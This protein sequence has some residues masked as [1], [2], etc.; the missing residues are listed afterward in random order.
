MPGELKNIGVVGLGLMGSSIIVSFLKAG[1]RVIALTPLSE[2]LEIGKKRVLEQLNLCKEMGLLSENEEYYTNNLII[3]DDYNFLK[4]CDLVNECVIEIEE[5]KKDV[6]HKIENVV[7]PKCIISTNTSAIPINILQQYFIKP[8]RFMGIHWA[9]PAY[10][11]RFLEITCGIKTNVELAE[12]VQKEAINWE[13][14]PTLLYKDIRGFITNRLMYAVYR[15]GFELINK[16]IVDLAGLDKCFQYDIGQWITIMGLF[17]RMDYEG[18]DKFVSSYS[19]I[20]PLLS[21]SNEVPPQMK[22][23][24]EING[25]GIHNLKGLYNHSSES[26]E[27]LE[28]NLSTFNE[29]IYKLADLYRI[30]LKQLKLS[31]IKK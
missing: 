25:R 11:T 3:C 6:Y 7:H 16:G 9:E 21:I 17:K 1:C 19:I 26:A 10:S 30:K 27:I 20:F 12:L 23:I 18:L 14:E 2:E 15:Q 31:E 8:D 28:D 4:D 22:K 24:L 29:E 13:K 5:I